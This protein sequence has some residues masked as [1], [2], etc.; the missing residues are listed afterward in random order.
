MGT[1]GEFVVIQFK[2]ILTISFFN[3]FHYKYPIRFCVLICLFFS[4]GNL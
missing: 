1:V 3:I 2:E 4:H